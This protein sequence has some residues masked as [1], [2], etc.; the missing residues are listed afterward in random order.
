MQMEG[1]EERGEG[2]M[3]EEEDTVRQM[4][5]EEGGGQISLHA[6]EGYPSEKTIKIRGNAGKSKLL[7]L[8][9]RCSS[10]SFLNENT[11]KE[12]LCVLQPT[13][14]LCVTVAN[15]HKMISRYKCPKFTWR[16]Q[17]H[18]FSG[19][20]KDSAAR[21]C[22]VVLGVDWMKTVSHSYSTLTRWR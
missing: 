15:G 13:P 8:I 14:P 22:Q 7:V 9:D 4:E 17:G 19:R 5:E 1:D 21:G 11:A 12:L 6:L 10:H 3:T 16:M 2:D 20:A 18:E